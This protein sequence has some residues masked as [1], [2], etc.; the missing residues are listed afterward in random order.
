MIWYDP[1]FIKI[2]L[3][4][5]SIGISCGILGCFIVLN[6]QS[7]LADTLAHATFPGICIMFLICGYKEPTYL[8]IGALISSISALCLLQIFE[9]PFLKKETLL[10]IILS[11]SF[12]LGI[13]LISIIQRMS[14]SEQAGLD[15]F[16]LGHASTV[17][18]HE[19]ACTVLLAIIISFMIWYFFKELK[20]IIFDHQFARL[21]GLRYYFIK[22]LLY[23]LIIFAM[24]IGLQSAGL[25]LIT[26]F[27]LAPAVAARQWTNHLHTMI[28]L[29]ICISVV[30]VFSGTTISFY[31]AHVPTGPCIV[32][33][34][35]CLTGISLISSP[36]S[37]LHA[38]ITKRKNSL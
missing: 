37:A 21:L 14:S 28:Y 11:T 1:L 26:S 24:V 15:K 17:L 12:G 32:I 33:I 31:Y 23:I 3:S 19:V 27:L 4:T 18:N 16:L 7:L 20:L 2:L 38:W 29:S 34:A 10:G 8:L 13:F 30:S 9:H 6:K 5:L 22:M 35:T 36:H 25:I